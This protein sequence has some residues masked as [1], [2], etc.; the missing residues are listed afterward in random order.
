M[1]SKISVVYMSVVQLLNGGHDKYANDLNVVYVINLTKTGDKMPDNH[2][3][4]I[5]G[6][7]KGGQGTDSLE[8]EIDNAAINGDILYFPM[9]DREL[10]SREKFLDYL[11]KTYPACFEWLLW[12][13]E[14]FQGKYIEDDV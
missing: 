12:H 13:P 10:E 14:I 9:N 2:F 4:Y 11:K 8:W 6:G 7:R 5:I 1:R 3:Q